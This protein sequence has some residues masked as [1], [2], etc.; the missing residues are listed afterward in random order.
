MSRR[1]I[2]TSQLGPITCLPDAA[3]EL[4]K[5]VDALEF[6]AIKRHRDM[7]I[8]RCDCEK[9]IIDKHVELESYRRAKLVLAAGVLAADVPAAGSD[10]K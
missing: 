10:K 6:G 5:A 3:D 1:L 8:Y 9:A 7:E 4:A 2:D